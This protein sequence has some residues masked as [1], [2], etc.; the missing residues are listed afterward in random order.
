MLF[1]ITLC[2]IAVIVVLALT[3]SFCDLF[4]SLKYHWRLRESVSDNPIALLQ[5][6]TF[7]G[8]S[9]FF[10]GYFAIDSF[11][12]VAGFSLAYLFFEDIEK[13]TAKWKS[14]LYWCVYYVHRILRTTILYGFFIL[15]VIA[16][17]EN[18]TDG[19]LFQNHVN[20]NHCRKYWWRNLLYI[21]N[22]YGSNDVCMEHLWYIAVEMQ[23]YI[24]APLV[25]IPLFLRPALG[26]LVVGITIIISSV[27]LYL[28]YFAYNFPTDYFGFYFDIFD[29]KRV[30]SYK[31]LVNDALW[32]RCTPYLIGICSARAL[33][34]IKNRSLNVSLA[35]LLSLWI[36]SLGVAC[37]CLFGL[38]DYYQ[39]PEHDMPILARASYNFFSRICWALFLSWLVVACEKNL[40][41]M[42]FIGPLKQFIEHRFWKPI[43]R[44]S[45]SVYIVHY[46]A[47]DFLFAR[48]RLILHFV[49][50]IYQLC[51]DIFPVI[52]GAYVCGYFWSALFEIPFIGIGNIIV[53]YVFRSAVCKQQFNVPLPADCKSKE[54]FPKELD[55]FG[56]IPSNVFGMTTVSMGSWEECLEV[57]VA[58]RPTYRT[59]FCYIRFA[60]HPDVLQIFFNTTSFLPFSSSV[61]QMATVYSPF[62]KIAS[63]AYDNCHTQLSYQWSVCLPRSCSAKTINSILQA[64]NSISDDSLKFCTVVCRS[65]IL[66]K[67]GHKL[68]LAVSYVTVGL[69]L[70]AV[71]TVYDYY[72]TNNSKKRRQLK[73]SLG[74]Q[75]L[76]AFSM[77]RNGGAILDVEKTGKCIMSIHSIKVIAMIWVI[78]GHALALYVV[79]DNPLAQS[80]IPKNI[81]ND[82]FINAFFSVDTFFFI[83][84]LLT[85]YIF[86]LQ[87]NAVPNRIYSV[88]Y[89][90]RF[91]CH[92]LI[93]IAPAYYLFLGVTIELF[94]YLRTGPIPLDGMINIKQCR[95]YWWYNIL[96]VNDLFDRLGQCMGHSWY[97]AADI[98]FYFLS[99]LIL[100]PLLRWP[101]LAY[102]TASVLLS[103]STIANYIAFYAYD[104]PINYVA[105]F[106]DINDKELVWNFEK[107]IYK[108]PWIRFTPYL[109][110][111][112]AG[113]FLFTL[114]N[115]TFRLHWAVVCILWI[116]N[117]TI[118]L[119]IIFGLYDYFK[120]PEHIIS[121]FSR[122]TYNN[123]SK[124]GWS[125]FLG[126]IIFAC[127][128]DYAGKS[129]KKFYGVGIMVAIQSIN[130]Y[131]LFNT[132]LCIG[133]KFFY[134]TPIDTFCQYGTR[135]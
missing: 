50:G 71:S 111:L 103:A 68:W 92:R 48:E 15:L 60:V 25:M 27:F 124:Y 12:F 44:L 135:C 41:G 104:F 116:L 8:N 100:V 107:Y 66:M 4:A 127:E 83:G 1:W 28:S 23:L 82:V 5:S 89:W 80:D 117:G 73:L 90:L 115:K 74:T 31:L 108:A 81:L 93:R 98:K 85:S 11:L 22:F 65:N 14:L 131:S 64:I 37:S 10:N 42:F 51:F 125:L 46:L 18:V 113:H 32:I 133:S 57:A 84:G 105:F 119:S 67:S 52:I 59:Q 130:V 78:S 40:A 109:L 26:A 110:G 87:I 58:S 91:Y 70:V 19:P 35:Q 54:K 56:R 79:S 88:H 34:Q 120:G 118:A 17:H 128:H 77:K 6:T 43:G 134:A 20:I 36:L 76:L 61:F 72:Y 129:F 123:F 97:I 49:G 112:F 33:H 29:A 75:I 9:L 86:F 114:R 3:S 126:W 2:G 24:L 132:H 13:Q 96:F 38:Y 106:A 63:N 55:S 47:M 121:T 45:Y 101:I 94:D 95:R 16:I 21:N 69:L 102:T 39:G 122:A 30:H 62:R 99:P 53:K 7:I